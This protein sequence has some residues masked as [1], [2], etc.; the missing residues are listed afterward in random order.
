MSG[1][2]KLIATTAIVC[3]VVLQKDGKILLV[4]EK[5]PKAYEKW[6]FPGGRVDAGE[7]L[8]LAAMREAKEES[9]FDVSIIKEILVMHPSVE[10]PVFH[11]YMAEI[12]GGEL[13][14]PEDEILDAKWFTKEEIKAMESEL[15]NPELQLKSLELI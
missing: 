12:I 15:R 9:G 1:Q 8:E 13:K 2:E 4:Q 7:T 6:N 3:S 11:I 14:F 10:R 5:Q